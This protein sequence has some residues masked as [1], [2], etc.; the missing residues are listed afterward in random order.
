[1]IEVKLG[2]ALLQKHIQLLVC[3]LVALF[4]LAVL[5]Q[6]LLHCVVGEVHG[7]RTDLEGVLRAGGSDVAVT[8]PVSLHLAV[9]AIEH[10]VVAQVELPLLVE[11]W[12]LDVLLEDVGLGGAVIVFLFSLQDRLDF[13]QVKTDH[14][15][16][17]AIR[18]LSWFHDPGVEFVNGLL[19]DLIVL[20]DGVEMLEELE[21]LVVFE[22]VLDVK[23]ERE[24]VEHSLSLARIVF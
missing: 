5:G 22:A 9:D 15:P 21:V 23:G 20:G 18:V 11:E 17:A 3:Y 19:I 13:T 10:E 4:V 12:P 1:L 16:V 24:V 2:I 6:I 7:A 14:D 8:V